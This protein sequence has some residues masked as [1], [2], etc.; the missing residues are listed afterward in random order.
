M[1]MRYLL[2]VLVVSLLQGQIIFGQSDAMPLDSEYWSTLKQYTTGELSEGDHE[3][4]CFRDDQKGVNWFTIHDLHSSQ[5]QV[6]VLSRGK[7]GNIGDSLWYAAYEVTPDG[8][9]R[10]FYCGQRFIPSKRR[11]TLSKVLFQLTDLDLRNKYCVVIRTRKPGKTFTL[12]TTESFRFS[13]SAGTP[14]LSGHNQIIYGTARMTNGQPPK[15]VS[16][17]LI[18]ENGNTVRIAKADEHG[19][20]VFPRLPGDEELTPKLVQD[21]VELDVYR[22]RDGEINVASVDQEGKYIFGNE[23]T[24]FDALRL[25]SKENLRVNSDKGKFGVVGKIVDDKVSAQGVQGI[26]VKVFDMHHQLLSE[27]IS[28]E[29]GE[30]SLA[31]LESSN[32]QL[33]VEELGDNFAEF[34]VVDD[35]NV[36]LKVTT[37]EL[38]VDGK[39]QFFA[40]PESKIEMLRIEELDDQS[41]LIQSFE[42]LTIGEKVILENVH[43]A[44]GSANLSSL[45]DVSLIQLAE[46]LVALDASQV[47]IVGH[48]DNVGNEHANQKLSKDRAQAVLMLLVE[49]GVQHKSL[50]AVGMGDKQPLTT[51]ETESGRRQNRR[52]EIVIV[53]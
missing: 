6:Q 7:W 40:L 8:Q 15:G 35:L 17:K 12:R 44:S 18:D 19:G 10:L 5:V 16:V 48:T 20:F 27:L 13:R 33:E 1:L 34:A 43:F 31:N 45:S 23:G 21:G 26:A 49:Q 41:S 51:N 46:R 28:N 24:N 30:I 39:F 9:K 14:A 11:I 36:P 3:P 38:M 22:L 53:E 50:T 47:K 4:T 32:I 42:E 29:A 37:S 52:V 25:L 2:F